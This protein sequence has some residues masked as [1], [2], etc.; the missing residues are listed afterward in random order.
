MGSE[1]VCTADEMDGWLQQQEQQQS[2]SQ[3]LTDNAV[4]ASS[5]ATS[6]DDS[7]AQQ[8]D[9]GYDKALEDQYYRCKLCHYVNDTN[10][11]QEWAQLSPR[12]RKRSAEA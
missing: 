10:S 11:D 5:A 4:A 1:C 8:K 9:E 7:L 6:H 12:D 3:R 2:A